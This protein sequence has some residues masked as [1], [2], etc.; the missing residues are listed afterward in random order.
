MK[1][2][3]L[4]A[5]LA[6][7]CMMAFACAQDGNKIIADQPGY[8]VVIVKAAEPAPVQAKVAMIK[9]KVLFDFDSYKIDAEADATIEKVAALMKANPD[10][11]LALDGHT[12]KYGAE[13]YNITLSLNRANAVKDALVDEGVPADS[14]AKVQGWGKQ[15]LIPDLTNRENRRVL[16]LSIDSK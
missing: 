7:V 5:L 1:V 4:L 9:E 12:D 15:Q 16:I 2:V 6:I 10:T 13:D 14:I 11:V 3:K 8:G